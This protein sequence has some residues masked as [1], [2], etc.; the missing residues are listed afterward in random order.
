MPIQ[1][2]K[3]DPIK[4]A[5]VY[6]KGDGRVTFNG[7][8][9]S[10]FWK[11]QLLGQSRTAVE[12]FKEYEGK[13]KADKDPARQQVYRNI[14]AVWYKPETKREAEKNAVQLEEQRMLSLVE[15]AAERD[16]VPAQL[17]E[18]L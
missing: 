10:A 3:L 4:K 13:L 11:G 5:W 14:L 17:E 18:P 12:Y 2:W 6:W 16:K 1:D 15:E 8:R 7:I 9:F